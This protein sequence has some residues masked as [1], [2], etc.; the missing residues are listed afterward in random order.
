LLLIQPLI[1]GVAQGCI[2]GL[3]AMGIV[4]I[5]QARQTVSLAQGELMVLAPWTAL[6]GAAVMGMPYWLA[7]CA[8]VLVVAAL[9]WLMERLVVRP[10]ALRPGWMITLATLGVAFGVR[11][12]ATGLTSS[13]PPNAVLETPYTQALWELAGQTV[14]TAHMAGIAATAVVCSALYGL[15]RFSK[16]GF[17]LQATLRNRMAAHH[18]GLPVRQLES[19]AWVLAAALAAIAGLLLA[20]WTP[21]DATMALTGLKALPAALL[22]GFM[23]LRGAMLGGIF[24]GLLEAA[25]NTVLPQTWHHSAV[26]AAALLIWVIQRSRAHEPITPSY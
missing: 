1:S 8:A 18:M 25:A 5:Y 26:F 21:V 24:L 6:V 19:V 14:H 17:G 20:T 4:L 12:L 9:G 16:L 15:F 3:V 23:G 7:V 11:L 2:Y 13:Q 10:L 22:T